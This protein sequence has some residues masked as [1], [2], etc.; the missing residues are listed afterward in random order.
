MT[1]LLKTL[2]ISL[3]LICSAVSAKEPD[4]SVPS[5]LF[6]RKKGLQPLDTRN[7]TPQAKQE[8]KNPNIVQAGSTAPQSSAEKEKKPSEKP[9]VVQQLAGKVPPKSLSTDDRSTN[10]AETK[11]IPEDNISTDNTKSTETEN[12]KQKIPKNTVSED[13]AP[14]E[15]ESIQGIN[16][17]DSLSEDVSWF[18][19]KKK[20]RH[21][22]GFVPIYSYDRSQGSR[23]GLRLLSY[24]SEK[25]GYYFAI[26]GSRYLSGPFSRW[27]LF[28]IGDRQGD[29]RTESSFI[30]DSHYDNY[31]G[32]GMEARLS[33]LQKLYARRL[34]ADHKV[35]YQPQQKNF[36]MGLRTQLF[37]RKE[38]PN[39]QGGKTYFDEEL[40]LFF[41]AFAGY[42]SR[43][44]WKNPEKGI[45][46]QLALGCKS[47][48]AFPGAYCRGEGD[49]RFYIPLFKNMNLHDS[50]K[51]SLLALR[52][53]AGSSFF[54]AGTY[55]TAYSLGGTD[56]FQNTNFMRGFQRN[57]FRGNKIY[58]SQ[59]EYRFPIWQKYLQGA[60]FLEAGETTVYEEPF[61]GF[62]V[63]YGGGL[64]IGL[65]P[66]YKMKLRFDFG[67]GKDYQGKRNYDLVISFLQ[68]F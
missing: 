40:F 53:F 47:V 20:T 32:M 15:K 11:N 18:F 6:S 46:H 58:I 52:L 59:L 3:S 51:N 17:L 21:K 63:D 61:K 26:S 44:N 41:S 68:A 22:I 8:V 2:V 65:P 67:T 55:S 54:S 35:F 33:D 19:Q 4:Q 14:K 48:L 56:L 31:F 12:T 27:T 5:F 43:D 23:L 42:D 57:R 34:V 60:L 29:W 7:R 16:F 49:F 10:K 64:R 30:Y 24:S 13:F 66:D 1:A 28:H 25:E 36:Y 38:R 50:L 62:V 45:F 37:F 39:L 9:A